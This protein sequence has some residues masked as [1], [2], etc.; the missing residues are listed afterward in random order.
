VLLP[1]VFVSTGR[2]V[3]FQILGT[4]T[5]SRAALGVHGDERE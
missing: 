1:L 2:G 3:H 4:L 5:L